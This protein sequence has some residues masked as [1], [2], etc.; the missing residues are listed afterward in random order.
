MNAILPLAEK[1]DTVKK[2]LDME[3][4]EGVGPGL[5][6][7]EYWEIVHCGICATDYLKGEMKSPTGRGLKPCPR[8]NGDT[9]KP[10]KFTKSP[11][12]LRASASTPREREGRDGHQSPEPKRTP[13]RKTDRPRSAS[14]PKEEPVS[15]IKRPSSIGAPGRPDKHVEIAIGSPMRQ[16][17]PHSNSDSDATI[18]V[19]DQFQLAGKFPVLPTIP[20]AP[21]PPPAF[22]SSVSR[23]GLTKRSGKSPRP[24]SGSRR[25][26]ASKGS[27]GS[28]TSTS[29]RRTLCSTI[30]C[31]GNVSTDKCGSCRAHIC[32]NCARGCPLRCHPSPLCQ[33]CEQPDKH[34][35][36]AKVLFELRDESKATIEALAAQHLEA[37]QTA[38]ARLANLETMV[39]E[40]KQSE[41]QLI[42]EKAEL[43]NQARLEIQRI[44]L[45]RQTDIAN[46]ERAKAEQMDL[47]REAVRLEVTA[48]LA[49]KDAEIAEARRINAQETA[50]SIHQRQEFMQQA[51]TQRE[52][53]I[54]QVEG[55]QQR[56][57]QQRIQTV[58]QSE[59]AAQTKIGDAEAYYETRLRAMERDHALE[60][61]AYQKKVDAASAAEIDRV[62]EEHA[63][64]NNDAERL[65]QAARNEEVNAIHLAT[66]QRDDAIFERDRARA[67]EAHVMAASRTIVERAAPTQV[68]APP[69]GEDGAEPTPPQEPPA[70]PDDPGR[71]LGGE[72]E[73]PPRGGRAMASIGR[74]CNFCSEPFHRICQQCHSE[75]CEKYHY[76]TGTGLCINCDR[77]R[78]PVCFI[79]Q[80]QAIGACQHCT[81]P[82][83]GKH[84]N[85]NHQC[86]SECL[87]A[88][89]QSAF[90]KGRNNADALFAQQEAAR[91]AR[92]ERVRVAA[93]V[94]P[95]AAPS[96]AQA[97]AI[98]GVQPVEIHDDEE[99]EDTEGAEEYEG[100]W[101]LGDEE[102]DK[103][104]HP[105]EED[106]PASRR[107][108]RPPPDDH[109]DDGPEGGGRGHRKDKKDK[110]DKKK[111][112][113]KKRKR[114]GPDGDSDPS[115]SSSS[116]D[117]SSS[118]AGAD[119]R[120][121][122][123]RK[124]GLHS[125]EKIELP[126]WPKAHGLEHWFERVCRIISGASRDHEEA[127]KWILRVKSR[128]DGIE[129]ELKSSGP[130]FGQ[131]DQRI[132]ADMLKKCQ[133]IKSNQK[134]EEIHKDIANAI[135][136]ENHKAH[137]GS[138]SRM[139]KGREMIRILI[140]YLSVRKDYS[141]HVTVN[142][143][144]QIVLQG[145]KD[146]N[147]K[148][149]H[150]DWDYYFGRFQQDCLDMPQPL[151]DM[152]HDHYWKQ[153]KDVPC[154][155]P[156]LIDYLRT[157]SPMGT[158]PNTQEYLR[159]QVVLY[160]DRKRH[161]AQTE[162][163]RRGIGSST[164]DAAPAKGGK[165]KSKGKTS[166]GESK[167]K[168]KDST[169]GKGKGKSG[170][171]KE[172]KGKGKSKGKGKGGKPTAPAETGTKPDKPPKRAATPP[173]EPVA[174]A[175]RGG[176]YNP[177][178]KCFASSLGLCPFAH[179][180][181]L[182]KFS[183]AKLTA[184]EKTFRDQ[185]IE[186]Q[187]KENKP[188]PW[189]T[190]RNLTIQ[191]Q[192]ATPSPRGTNA[193]AQPKAKAKAKCKAYAK[194]SCKNG[195]ACNYAH[196]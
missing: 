195:D 170:G 158:E 68:E 101:L 123:R 177:K 138:P 58:E 124:G 133:E 3:M 171:S 192:A 70:P 35:C 27:L 135:T 34:G 80:G 13:P 182:C 53:V 39:R 83:C 74:S 186:K 108:R 33:N 12:R 178:N 116:S 65:R 51:M 21:G 141:Q 17:P 152:I 95:V 59:A 24:G 134:S 87:P 6:T 166:K 125:S 172:E 2:Q 102:E 63:R 55:Q 114:G 66:K 90:S 137:S 31:C 62:R 30:S 115:S 130:N 155:K 180:P 104:E 41:I 189:E 136:L 168:G 148:K 97:P 105:E 139:M 187:R 96:G 185:W 88:L 73:Q 81:R 45:Q 23:R 119:G 36:V 190:G 163:F 181:A 54:V 69:A 118:S 145:D 61:A 117:S 16:S 52:Q 94:P 183:H 43:E 1:R 71:R 146:K 153:V 143:L 100:D 176:R 142:D 15:I 72:P 76:A 14:A 25:S 84:Q 110:K 18:A 82:M 131:H 85:E 169:G 151:R 75:V 174:A 79:C 29:S 109:G 128:I 60:G 49:K 22:D 132:A 127:Y 38:N 188:I 179:N 191:N 164:Q 11:T 122:R 112:K 167:G 37:Q 144:M 99:W 120:R 40:S 113:K 4:P 19:P 194:G 150:N 140:Y 162:S 89:M 103:G 47:N 160:L 196:E 149:F 184:E 8:C 67:A 193:A 57:L 32:R 147:L 121:E 44:E 107:R 173:P 26:S 154:L 20:A 28:R 161:D 91:A 175:A 129:E 77:V 92:R 157:E 93:A 42:K 48:Q 98:G 10:G 111:K 9:L 126:R 86:C 7:A 165:G 56:A 156:F 64:A 106:D 5:P 46:G 159:K 50:A 78:R